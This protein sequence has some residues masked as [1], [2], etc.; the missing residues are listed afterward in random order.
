MKFPT[1][2]SDPSGL[3]GAIG[4]TTGAFFGLLVLLGVLEGEVAD[5]LM[6]V[7]VT[8]G[9]LLTALGIRRFAYAPDTVEDVARHVERLNGGSGAP[10]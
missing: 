2:Q 8:L 4:T 3:Y 5:G 7:V 1:N 9:P 6:A 10:V